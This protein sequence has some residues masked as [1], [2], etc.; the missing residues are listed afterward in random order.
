MSKTNGD[1]NVALAGRQQKSADGS[2]QDEEEEEH[3]DLKNQDHG[4]VSNVPPPEDKK[5][6]KKKKKKPASKRGLDKPTGFED[7]FADAP[8]TPEE[9]AE[10]QELYDPQLDF[11]DRILTA[12]A[13]FERTRKLTPERR[14]VLYK[15]LA[16]GG[17]SVGPNVGQGS[18][19]TEGLSKVEVAQA[20]S[21]V[22]AS[23]DKRDLGTETSLYEVDFLGCIKSFLSRRTKNVWG[24]E[25]RAQVDM[26]CTTI[27]RFLDYLLQHDV[28][29]E[30]GD[31]ILASRSFCRVAAAELW[32]T[33]EVLRRLPGDFNIACSTLFDGSYAHNYD[34]E[35]WWGK[36]DEGVPVFVGMKPEEAQQIVKFGVAGAANE[37]VYLG[38][39]DGVQNQRPLMLDVIDVQEHMG[40]E[41]TKIQPP[42]KECKQIYTSQ[43]AQFRP[44]GRVTAK[45]WRDLMALA[46]DLTDA[47][48]EAE[49]EA[50]ATSPAEYVFFVESILQSM[51]RVGTKIEATVRTL[52]CGIMFFDEVLNVYPSFDEFIANEM[53]IGWK[54]P[55][56]MNGA[57]DYVPGEDS[58]GDEGE[59]D[60]P[61]EAGNVKNGQR[62]GET[63][64]QPATDAAE[65]KYG[66]AGELKDGDASGHGGD[67]FVYNEG[68]RPY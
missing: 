30:Y 61:T 68:E 42:S 43:S 65:A 22:F 53:L 4:V 63:V 50:E 3:D 60:G 19:D 28:C 1:H 18:V 59:E 37:N 35:T 33:A 11:V 9:H 52:G 40:F 47:E 54:P 41:I 10:D 24:L 39:L 32:D 49:R 29:P 15:Y 36:D 5:K 67:A 13:R 51:L 48:R 34:G 12:I 2:V 31:D 8:M 16:Y 66:G 25:T 44:V 57:N 62:A 58:D 27:E 38:F 7:F 17:L 55:K 20:L 26:I 23:E 14:D 64:E 46:E 45:R 21:Q 56:P 6:K